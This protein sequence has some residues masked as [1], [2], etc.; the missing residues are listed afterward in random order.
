T[1]F[2]RVVKI[3]EKFE[4]IALIELFC[5]DAIVVVAGSTWLEDDKE[6]AHYV[7][8]KKTTK[9][10][11]APHDITKDRLNECNK[12]YKQSVLFSSLNSYLPASDIN[13]I[14]I[15]N[16]GMLSRLYKYA[17]MAYVGG[18]FGA[19]GVHNV[20]EA[21]VYGKPVVFGP[22]YEKFN[23]AIEL[24]ESGGGITV[25]SALELEKV[26]DDLLSD[27]SKYDEKAAASLHY[28]YSNCGATEK[29]VDFVYKNLLLTS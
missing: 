24:V 19:D 23:E 14:I 17:S 15:D 3:A 21:A 9:F 10:I 7:N 4:P 16:V 29:I 11:I 1:R 25:K 22:E 5:K 2:D 28:V 8:N 20:L 27:R 13:T 26:F 12:L 6:L 18:G